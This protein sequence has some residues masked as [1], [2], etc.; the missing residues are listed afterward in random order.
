LRLVSAE[1][2]LL[3]D[4]FPAQGN[5]EF[6]NVLQGTLFDKQGKYRSAEHVGELA[7]DVRFWG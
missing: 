3:A 1:I 5:R 6:S 7:S 2:Q 4:K